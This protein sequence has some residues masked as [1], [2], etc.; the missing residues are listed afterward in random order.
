MSAMTFEQ[1]R[2]EWEI[3]K[4]AH[5]YAQAVDRGDG[6]AWSALFATGAV[7]RIGDG[8]VV[9]KQALEAIPERQLQRYAKTF[10]GILTQVIDLRGPDTAGGEVYCIARHVYT[11]YHNTPGS[12]PFSLSHDVVIKYRDKYRKE[13]GVWRF[14]ERALAIDFRQVSQVDLFS[15]NVPV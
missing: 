3:G 11:D 7:L 13:D 2:D 10:H 15:G 8:A 5:R 6:A 12:M 1:L 9:P 14:A 4:L